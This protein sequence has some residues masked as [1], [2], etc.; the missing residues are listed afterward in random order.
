VRGHAKSTHR[1][2]IEPYGLSAV[3]QHGRACL[4]AISHPAHETN[5][6]SGPPRT[7]HGRDAKASN[8]HNLPV[9]EV[10]V[11]CAHRRVRG[12]QA[13]E[14]RPSA[15]LEHGPA[16]QQALVL[17]DKVGQKGGR[18]PEEEAKGVGHQ[19]RYGKDCIIFR[20]LSP[21][22]PACLPYRIT[23]PSF[24]LPLGW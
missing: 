16:P 8:G 7:D 19:L 9:G 6:S 22:R 5:T 24:R 18:R 20:C 10:D 4:P 1:L 17:P 23:L 2:W 11:P 12:E 13:G 14:G 21:R 3:I 15:Q